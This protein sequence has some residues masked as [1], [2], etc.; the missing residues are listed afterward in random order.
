ERNRSRESA[1]QVPH[2][3]GSHE[4]LYQ[5]RLGAG[6]RSVMITRR[7]VI[8]SGAAALFAPAIVSSA[9]AQ[10]FPSRFVRIIVPFPPGG[11]T[12]AIARVVAGRL[13][14][15]WG[16]QAGVENSRAGAPT[17]VSAAVAPRPPPGPP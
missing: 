17:T 14:E 2:R 15:M 3:T 9:I 16:Q 10:A 13:S 7:H 11:G 1:G 12:D 5:T 8:S 4:C 6:L